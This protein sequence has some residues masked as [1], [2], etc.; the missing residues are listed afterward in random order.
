MVLIIATY[1]SNAF[2]SF[3]ENRLF[4]NCFTRNSI[5]D[6]SY[7]CIIEIGNTME[8]IIIIII[9]LWTWPLPFLA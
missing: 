7:V 4:A 6:I 9:I 8:F 1:V 3:R 5:Y 2:H